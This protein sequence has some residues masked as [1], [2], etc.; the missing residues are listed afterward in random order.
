MLL[1]TCS[2]NYDHKLETRVLI[3]L[4]LQQEL[5]NDECDD[6]DTNELKIGDH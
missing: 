4:G 5:K 6:C 1:L 2:R 3:L